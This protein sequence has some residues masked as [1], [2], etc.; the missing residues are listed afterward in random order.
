MNQVFADSYYWLALIHK[1]DPDHERVRG[2]EVK[3]V[4]VTSVAVQLEVMDALS[5]MALRPA[6]NSFWNSCA[7]LPNLEVV[8]LAQDLLERSAALFAARPDKDWSLT[9]C[10][11]FA[12][13]QDCG[14]RLAL[15]GDHHFVQ[16]G[17]EIA[18]P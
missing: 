13:M 18:F 8:P 6:A 14:I 12:I 11:A 1:R 15:T 2:Y 3:G 9:D 10:I 16:A 17:F 7:I 4:M 5:G